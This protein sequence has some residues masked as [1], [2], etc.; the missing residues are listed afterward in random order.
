M[1]FITRLHLCRLLFLKLISA[2]ILRL[3]FCSNGLFMSYICPLCSES[4]LLDNRTWRC[5]NNHCFDKAKEGYVNLLPVQKKHSKDPGD[6]KLMMQ[7][8]R[9]FLEA[10]FYQHL[11]D[12]VNHL[13]QKHIAD[14]RA[15]LLDLGFAVRV[16]TQDE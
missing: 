3:L 9:T 15:S 7:A 6:N 1:I 10:G 12:R 16:I 8:R 14:E 2:T 13:A 4:L 5:A 11:S